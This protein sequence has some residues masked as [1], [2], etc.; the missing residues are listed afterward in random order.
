[1]QNLYLKIKFLIIKMKSD[2]IISKQSIVNKNSKYIKYFKYFLFD[3]L[4]Y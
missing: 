4:T 1:M 2:M 3:N